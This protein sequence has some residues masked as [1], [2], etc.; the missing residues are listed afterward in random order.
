ML[1]Q[2]QQKT[3]TKYYVLKYNHTEISFAIRMQKADNIISIQQ[4]YYFLINKN[5]SNKR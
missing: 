2:Q 5:K 1:Q 3:N 4:K